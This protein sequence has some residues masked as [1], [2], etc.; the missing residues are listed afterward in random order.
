MEVSPA[1]SPVTAQGSPIRRLNHFFGAAEPWSNRGPSSLI[2]HCGNRL[3]LE[4]SLSGLPLTTPE[5]EGTLGLL[6]VLSQSGRNT[7]E[8]PGAIA[9]R[10]PPSSADWSKQ[11]LLAGHRTILPRRESL[12]WNG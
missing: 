2:F 5:H 11:P 12:A 7:C 1:L 6:H 8:R 4:G 10:S 9:E 3:K